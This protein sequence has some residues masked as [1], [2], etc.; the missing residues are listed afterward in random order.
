MQEYGIPA[1]ITLAQACLES[2]NGTGRLAREANNHFGIKCHSDWKG[3]TIRHTDDAKNECFRKYKNPEDSFKDHADFLRYWGRYAFLFE[4][5]PYDYKG[6]A[7]GLKK[8]GY[9]TNPQYAELLIK[10]IEDY[11]LYQYDNTVTILPESPITIERPVVIKPDVKSPLYTASLHRTI[12]RRNHVS[13]IFSQPGDTYASLAKEFRLFRRELLRFN[14]LKKVEPLLPGTLVY[15]EKKNKQSTKA[16][17]MH[18]TESGE[19]LRSISQR[20]AVRLSYICKYNKIN[21][22]EFLPEGREIILRKP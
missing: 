1:S 19:S 14:D 21:K 18:I 15:V 5:P 20:Y 22:N 9:A 8:A 2:G 11:K 17:P 6:W 3:Q 16:L 4:L 12:Y 13:C 10:I 7:Q